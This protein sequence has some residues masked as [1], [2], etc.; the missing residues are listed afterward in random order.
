MVGMSKENLQN[1]VVLMKT[2]AY[3]PTSNVMFL[4][5]INILKIVKQKPGMIVKIFI[6]RFKMFLMDNIM[7]K[8]VQELVQ[9]KILN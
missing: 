8:L 4:S 7:L 9:I 6:G 3:Q 1:K 5:R 2:K